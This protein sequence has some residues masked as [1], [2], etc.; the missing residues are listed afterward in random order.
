MVIL[1]HLQVISKVRD[2]LSHTSNGPFLNLLVKVSSTESGQR[3]VVE[4]PG[5]W[6]EV[7]AGS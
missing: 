6:S 4:I 3:A 2:D 5:V 1:S 7:K